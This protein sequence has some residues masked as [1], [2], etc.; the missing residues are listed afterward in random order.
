MGQRDVAQ[1]LALFG[2]R[3]ELQLESLPAESVVEQRGRAGAGGG[4]RGPAG[5]GRGGQPRGRQLRHLPATA[6][7]AAALL[8]LRE[9]LPLLLRVAVQLHLPLCGVHLK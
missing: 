1:V 3:V 7:A 8:G 4:A 6:R 5:G 2:E 9:K